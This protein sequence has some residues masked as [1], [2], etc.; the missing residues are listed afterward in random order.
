MFLIAKMALVT[1]AFYIG[2]SVLLEVGL[3][4]AAKTRGGILYTL[5][6]MAWGLVFGVAWLISFVLAWR[7]FMTPFLNGFPKPPLK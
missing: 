7:V 6:P 2:V 5:N 3:L 4:V 1:C